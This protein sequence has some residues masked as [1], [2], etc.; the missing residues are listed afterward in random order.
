MIVESEKSAQAPP[1]PPRN[2]EFDKM[3]E[4]QLEEE[5]FESEVK[6]YERAID[7]P[8]YME[9]KRDATY[10][11]RPIDV[12]EFMGREKTAT[13][14]NDYGHKNS[15]DV[16]LKNDD[17]M[18]EIDRIITELDDTICEAERKSRDSEDALTR[19]KEAPFTVSA[20]KLHHGSRNSSPS[21]IPARISQMPQQ[22]TSSENVSSKITSSEIIPARNGSSKTRSEIQSPG[23]SLL[24]E[25]ITN[26]YF[27][28][29]KSVEIEDQ[30]L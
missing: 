8:E 17:I 25:E 10:S 7:V 19:L 21:P 15:D 20:T 3:R 5:I 6:Y 26:K 24:S 29:Q 13:K 28:N 1:K 30:L 11:E 4:N 14:K 9:K 22:I 18:S 16:L 2:F 23:I 27:K 12:P